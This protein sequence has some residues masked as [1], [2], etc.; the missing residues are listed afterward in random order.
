[1][2]ELIENA[3][4][5]GGHP[6]AVEIAIQNVPNAIE[7]RIEDNGTGLSSQETAVL[8]EGVETALIHGSGLGLWLAHWVIS[9]HGGSIHP[10][11]SD[12]G[13]TMT[14][15]IPRSP[16][17]DAHQDLFELKRARDQYEA[18]FDQAADAMVIINDDRQIIDANP[19]TST[20]YGMAHQELLGH[21]VDRFLPNEFDIEAAW[22]EFTAKGEVRDRIPVRGADGARRVVEYTAKADVVP[23]QHLIQIRQTGDQ[24]PNITVPAKSIPSVD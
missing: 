11:V 14:V 18:C 24:L 6:P 10:V 3:A 8:E 4:K 16:E 19:K 17:S 12:E 22:E 23:G 2:T 1:M 21:E 20:I 7:I 15:T 13:T 5:H 9:S